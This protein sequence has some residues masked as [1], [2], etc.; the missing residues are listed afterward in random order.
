MYLP[1]DIVPADRRSDPGQ[2]DGDE[3]GSWG[4]RRWRRWKCVCIY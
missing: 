1:E 2:I 3:K 4:V